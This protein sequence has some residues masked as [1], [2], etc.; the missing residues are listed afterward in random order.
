MNSCSIPPPQLLSPLSE[1]SKDDASLYHPDKEKR[2]QMALER[3][4]ESRECRFGLDE[5]WTTAEALNGILRVRCQT[6]CSFLK[7]F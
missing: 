3:I 2:I 1:G 4:C 6:F 7:I 5:L